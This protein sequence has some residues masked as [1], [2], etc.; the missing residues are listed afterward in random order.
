MLLQFKARKYRNFKNEIAINFDE[1]GGY[2]FNG[3][4]ITNN[5]I[6]KMIVYGRNATGKTNLGQA[7]MDINKLLNPFPMRDLNDLNTMVSEDDTIDFSYLFL[8][9]GRKVLYSYKRFSNGELYEE[10]LNIDGEEIFEI[11]FEKH[12]FY[13]SQHFFSKEEIKAIQIYRDRIVYMRI[14]DDADYEIIPFVR[15]ASNNLALNRKNEILSIYNF[16]R[17]MQ[18]SM[19][20]NVSSITSRVFLR[21]LENE[22]EL[23]R[24]ENF[25]NMMGVECTLELEVLPDGA[26]ELYFIKG[27]KLPFFKNASSGTRILANLYRRIALTA[28]RSTFIYLDEF[29]A[30]FHYEMS[31]RLVEFFKNNYPDTQIIF[32][33]HNTNLMSNRFMRPDCLFILSRDGRLTSLKNATF[34]ELREGHNLEKMYISGEFESHE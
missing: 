17:G 27:R 16:S 25:L 13:V 32:T 11:N 7:L 30:F 22:E 3:N 12:L 19:D 28:R 21:M 20:Y 2:Q 4:C 24:F 5:V 31:E 14:E 6:S 1:I 15:W 33:T 10:R 8:F 9:E 34:R 26:R 23:H 29:D 18:M